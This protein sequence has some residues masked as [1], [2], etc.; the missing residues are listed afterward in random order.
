VGEQ[1]LVS[2]GQLLQAQRQFHEFRFPQAAVTVQIQGLH[3]P[4]QQRLD[5]RVG[6]A[7]VLDAKGA[8]QLLQGEAAAGIAIEPAEEVAQPGQSLKCAGLKAG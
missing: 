2:L 4:I 5:G 7:R 6:R 3:K 1:A 8:A